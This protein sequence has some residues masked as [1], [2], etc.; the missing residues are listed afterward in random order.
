MPYL[1]RPKK[2]VVPNWG[3]QRADPFLTSALWRNFRQ[4][5]LIEQPLCEACLLAEIMT[6]ITGNGAAQIDHIVRREDGGALVD[7]KNIS[8]LCRSCHA[9]KTALERHGLKI[10]ASGPPGSRL[11]ALGEKQRILQKIASTCE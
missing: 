9:K 1:P 5:V 3:N 11:P 10:E 8:V 4:C 2:K 7:I 6:D